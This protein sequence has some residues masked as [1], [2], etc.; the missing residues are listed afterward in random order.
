MYSVVIM[1]R[2]AVVVLGPL[3]RSP[4]ML[5]HAV[6]FAKQSD[7][8]KVDFIGYKGIMPEQFNRLRNAKA[9]NLSTGY[10]VFKDLPRVFYLFYALFRIAY[11]FV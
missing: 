10:E 9:V 4:R 3:D 5:N 7:E 2:I 6:S 1:A 11:Q 8:N